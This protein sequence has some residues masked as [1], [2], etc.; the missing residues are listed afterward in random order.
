MPLSHTTEAAGEMSS[1]ISSMLQSLA[2]E[3]CQ[4]RH[5]ELQELVQGPK[6]IL[7]RPTLVFESE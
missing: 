6:A 3:L 1:S 4:L 2:R 5:G 7:W